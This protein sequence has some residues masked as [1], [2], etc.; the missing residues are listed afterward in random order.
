[1]CL[2]LYIDSVLLQ[3]KMSAAASGGQAFPCHLCFLSIWHLI[4]QIQ[5]HPF[6]I[7]L[8]CLLIFLTCTTTFSPWLAALPSPTLSSTLEFER[9]WNNICISWVDSADPILSW[10]LRPRCMNDSWL[11]SQCK[12]LLYQRILDGRAGLFTSLS[13]SCQ[14]KE[15]LC[16]TVHETALRV[17]QRWLG[18]SVVCKGWL[19]NAPCLIV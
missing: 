1:M 6:P 19:E 15:S 7:L 8:I 9:G 14:E 2:Q 3:I 18:L 12:G 10:A 13:M 17:D 16:L 5:P 4:I 11:L